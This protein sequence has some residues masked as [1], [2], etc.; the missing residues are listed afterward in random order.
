MTTIFTQEHLRLLLNDYQIPTI[1]DGFVIRIELSLYDK[2]YSYAMDEDGFIIP[3]LC[4]IHDNSDWHGNH[5]YNTNFGTASN[6]IT[7]WK[8]FDRFTNLTCDEYDLWEALFYK[9]ERAIS[10]L[11]QKIP[12][13]ALAV[14]RIK[15]AS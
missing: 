6:C 11:K 12:N 4:H 1:W 9:D 15:H 10:K 13:F 14:V 3:G 7:K 8:Y 5:V 2:V